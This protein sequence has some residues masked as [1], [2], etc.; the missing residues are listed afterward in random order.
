MIDT[1][2]DLIWFQCKPCK[3]YYNQTSPI[4]DPSKSSSYNI[5]PCS[6]PTCTQNPESHCSLDHMKKCEY[7]VFYGDFSKSKGY[8]SE[9]ILTLISNDG[10]PVTFSN[11]VIGCGHKNNF[12]ID[13]KISGFIGLGRGPL[14][15]VSQLGSSIGRKFSYCLVP[16]FSQANIPSK[17]NFGD[18]SV[19]SGIG[20]VS[21]PIVQGDFGTFYVTIL[22]A[23]SVGNETI[24]LNHTNFRLKNPGNTII[25]SGSTLVH[26][27]YAIYSRL[28]S[29]VASLVK[30]KRV[31]DPTQ[32]MNLCYKTTSNFLKV[33][34]ITA[35]F[36]GADV[37]LNA[38]NTFIPVDHKVVCFAFVPN[39]VF[40]YVTFGNV[41]QQN[42]L[43]GYDLL[44]NII[45]FKPTD[46]AKY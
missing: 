46:C 39:D 6:S 8:L 41:A 5:I 15:L 45:S 17:L 3:S 4:F 13:G 21:T 25:D 14:S 10:S 19:V 1:G 35:H 26:L 42:F 16:F 37:H 38:L 29:A 44:K 24:K 34:I 20:T 11:I 43:V 32:Q 28:E 30:L 33:P 22:E 23:F 27:P 18:T 40:D 2:S 9:D 7:N 31:K 12:T 36:M